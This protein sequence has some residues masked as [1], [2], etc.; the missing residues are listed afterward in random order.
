MRYWEFASFSTLLWVGVL[1]GG[2]AFLCRSIPFLK[3][4]RI[5]HSIL[6]GAL[7]LILG[8]G[9]LGVI[10]FS[11]AGLKF[12]I[13]HGLAITFIAIG[14]RAPP[15]GSSTPNTVAM[16]LAMPFMAVLQG[17]VGLSVVLLLGGDL[18]PG[19]GLLLPLGFN[20][21]PGQAMSLGE[22]W[23]ATGFIDG[24]QLGL[25][26]AAV[27]FAWSVIFGIPLVYYLQRKGFT[28][29]AYESESSE[30]TSD[31]E[32][33]PLGQTICVI[34]LVYLICFGVLKIMHY[35][36]G[37]SPGHQGMIWG[38]HFLIALIISVLMRITYKKVTGRDFQRRPL[39]QI[40]NLSV[41]WVTCSAIAAIQITILQQNWLAIV[42]LT[43]VGLV[44]TLG[45][46][47]W[48]GSR[49]FSS[50]KAEHAIVWFGASTGTLPMGLALLRMVDPKLQSAAPSSVA[51]GSM[52]SLVASIPLL[53]LV[54]PY[55]INNYPV[56]HPQVSI[57]TLGILFV[58][59]VVI[60]G[61][62]W[63][64]SG[65]EMGNA[66]HFWRR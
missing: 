33:D 17:L 8:S 19:L 16:G 52:I 42:V 60:G 40:T 29:S 47:M 2:T 1:L 41:D 4:S 55:V 30:E 21:G 32:F 27:G 11:E 65:I 62:W 63:K 49:G 12:L 3:K 15:S 25:I 23:E 37:S 6:A 54:M 48:W 53:I 13:Y 9:L 45:I 34:C 51:M 58:Y 10:P 59:A 18:H 26:I 66:R 20:Q 44:L 22:A 24:G 28:S 7:G 43:S 57:Q 64:Y 38:F 5:P 31:D 14:L 50:D 35:S 61:V 36:L 56:G 39:G 46:V